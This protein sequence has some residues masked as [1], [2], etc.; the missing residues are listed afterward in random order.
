MRGF[1]FFFFIFLL[2]IFGFQSSAGIA[3]AADF[4][5]VDLQTN[6]YSPDGYS[7]FAKNSVLPGSKIKFTINYF[8]DMGAGNFSPVSLENYRVRWFHKDYNIVDVQGAKTLDYTINK[9]SKDRSL[10]FLI[11]VSD[12]SGTVLV[13][14]DL[15]IPIKKNP[16]LTF[17]RLIDNKVSF[18]N[19]PENTFS[20]VSGQEINVFVKP[21]FFNIKSLSE[22]NF[23]WYYRLDKIQNPESRKYIFQ[24]KLP[25]AKIKDLFSVFV[26][27]SKAELE[28][29]KIPF[30]LS[31]L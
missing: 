11:Q 31:T 12:K 30:Y 2:L 8:K 7:A 15:T 24:A 4:I 17:H 25:Q 3:F 19:E 14:K 27:N 10:V 29:V 9:F 22:L 6:N 16:E 1:R 28:F 20:G 26:Q 13:Q 21:Y 5:L 18:Y 23:Q